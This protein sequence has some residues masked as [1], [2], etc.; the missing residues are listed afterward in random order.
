MPQIG[1]NEVKVTRVFISYAREDQAVVRALA[2][3][4]Q[5]AGL[6]VW[7]D[8]NLGAGEAFRGSIEEQLQRSDVILVVWSK[9]AKL[10]RWVLD[11]AEMGVQRGTL[12][13]LRIDAAAPPLGFGG[14]NTLNFGAW[15]G[16]FNSQE[17]R[18]LLN[19][20][21]KIAGTLS[22]PAARPAIRVLPRA[23]AVAVGFGAL[24]SG[25][26]W[27]L[28][29]LTNSTSVTASLLGHPIIDAF[30]LAFVC[31]LPIALWS[32]VEVKRAGFESFK[33][34][35]RRS[36]LLLFKGGAFALLVVVA[37]IAAGAVRGAA[38]REI[39]L[40]LAR[41]SV[42]ATSLSA[43]VLAATN[44]VWFVVRRGFGMKEG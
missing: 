21:N 19:E 10:S 33:L 43:A 30:F 32:A 36:F 34:I 35:V 14:F 17:W 13:P 31:C 25:L 4:L 11:E 8:T 18:S 24:I 29:S 1:S 26:I 38:P 5:R 39:A 44:L 16:D 23:F 2:E 22:L 20:I 28:Y 15:G 37:A 3:G 7:W 42:V 6:D 41:I 27:G 40:E 9:R 12:L